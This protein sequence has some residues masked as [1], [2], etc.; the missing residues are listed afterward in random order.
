MA[1][2]NRIWNTLRSNSLQGELEEELRLH[3]ELRAQELERSGIS[4]EEARAAALRQFGNTTLETERMRNMD[5]AAW[6]ETLVKDLRYA[7]RQFLRN[8]VFTAVAVLSLAIGIGANTA[9]FG[10]LNSILLKS[11]PVRAPHELV[12]L[13][14]P[15]ASGVSDGLDSGVRSLMTYPE[16]A[17]L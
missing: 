14:D 3:L 9:I 5:I 10:A 6:M 1:W 15:N 7:L 12:L 8:P 16:F 11:L 13:T 17:Q 4:R 2:L